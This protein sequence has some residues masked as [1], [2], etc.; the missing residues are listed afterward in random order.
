M[1]SDLKLEL[2]VKKQITGNSIKDYPEI[3]FKG[4]E[5]PLVSIIIPVYN[6]FDYTY[7]C[8]RSIFE[9]T[10]DINYEIIIADDCSNDLTKN[11]CE[12]VKGIHVEKTQGQSYFLRNCNHAAKAA[13][14]KY[15]VFLNN[16][17]QVQ[18][19]WL[20]AFSRFNGTGF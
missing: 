20:K 14:G 13:K 1:G 17:T 3:V 8:L 2:V 5:N 18:E 12:V 15:I 11:I 4:A 6:Q 16:D 7:A 10:G 9:N 19:N